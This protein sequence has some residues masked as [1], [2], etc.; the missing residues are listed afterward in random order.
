MAFADE[1]KSRLDLV[2]VVASYVPDLQQAGRSFKAR[3]PFHNERTPSFFV[4]PERQTWRCFGACATGGDVFSFVMATEKLAFPE[5]LRLLAQRAGVPVPQQ[6]RSDELHPLQQINEAAWAFFQKLLASRQGE[7]ARAYLAQRGLLP[8][9]VEEFGLGLSPAGGTTLIEHLT[10][11]GYRPEAIVAAGVATQAEQGPARDLFRG[12]LTFPIHDGEGRLSGF[13]GRALDGS[14]PK[15]LNSPRTELFDKGRLLYALHRARRSMQQDGE[16][17]VVEGYMDA[18]VAHQAG[19][20]NVTASMGTA[21]TEHQVA[22]LRGAARRVVLALDADAAGQEATFRSLET[23]WQVFQDQVVARLRVGTLYQRPAEVSLRIA[24][25]PPGKDP[26]EVILKDPAQWERLLREAQDLVEYLFVTAPRRWPLATSQG[27]AQA[28]E[29]LY[30][31]IAALGNPFEEERQLR[32]LAEALG[33]SLATLEASVGRPRPRP[34]QRGAAAPPRAQASASPFEAQRRDA[35]EE[36]LLALLLQR[37][38]LREHARSLPPQLFSSGEDREIFTRWMRCP[39]LEALQSELQE[40]LRQRLDALFAFSL[41]PSDLRQREQAAKECCFRLQER[42]LR[43]LKEE[44]ALM[45]SSEAATEESK[46]QLEQQV[47]ETNE[48]LRS[49]FLSRPER[50]RDR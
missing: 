10:A 8:A 46:A 5:A 37:P 39:T 33:V 3:C 11:L 45:L 30:G 44:E 21:L 12:R 25:L 38:E 14:E 28:A 2:E 1:V 41:P 15:Y 31:I 13:G 35:L 22:L 7:G 20:R 40:E 36:Y 43:D 27:K 29:H 49:L 17:V 16:A 26:D 50:R 24:V 42:H 4:F 32:R 18:I 48:R 34:R 47:V 6:R 23:S 9:T 19:F